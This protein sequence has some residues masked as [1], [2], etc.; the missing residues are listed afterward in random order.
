MKKWMLL[1]LILLVGKTVSANFLHDIADGNFR[2]KR[3]DIPVS[4]NDGEHFTRMTDDQTIVRISFR[5]GQV[6]DTLFSLRRVRNPI[7]SS[8][9]GYI[10]S[11]RETRILVYRNVKQ[12]YRRSYTAEYYIYDIR[13]RELD[14]LSQHVPQEAPVFSPDDRY[15]A[16]AHNN[17]LHMKKADFKSE[18]QITRDGAV[19]KISNGI[20]D[21]LYEEEFSA[22]RFFDW[23]PDSKLLAFV[24]FDESEVPTFGFQ[25][26]LNAYGNEPLLYPELVTFKYP[27]AG[28]RNPR[29]S[30]H[31]YDDFNKRTTTMQL[32]ERETDFYVP[33]IMWTRSSDQLAI[34]VMNR[35][36]NRLDMLF[37]NPRSGVSRLIQR[38]ES[39]QY[40]DYK[41][42]DF[43]YFS[44]N[45]TSFF[46]VNE[47]DGFRHIYEYRLN[48]SL[49]R[50]VTR[51]NWEVTDFY[52]VDEARNLVYFQ[53]NELSPTRRDVFVVNARGNKTRLSQVDG[54]SKA[55]FSDNFNYFVL[56]ES[57][58]TLPNRFSL[59]NHRGQTLRDL[60]S[61]THLLAQLNKE[62]AGQKE[63]F[64]FTTP[65]N[66]TLHGW[67]L[68]P[69]TFNPN[70]RHP[71]VLMQYSGPG[72]QQ[73]LEQW[74][75][76]WEYYL[77]TQ[78]YV[79]VSVDGRG[80]GGRGA[81]FRNST[82][83][84]LGVLETQD[85]VATARHF[86]TQSF[87][88]PARIGIFGWSY[89]GS[90]TLWSMSSGANI[91]KAGIAV[92]PVT[93]W[94]FYD[95][96]YT[97]RF[98]RT[99]EENMRGYE[100]TSALNQVDRLYGRLLLVHGTADDNVHF[101]NTLAYA[102]RLVEAGKQFEMQ[103]YTDKNHSITGKQTRRHLFTRFVDFF[104]RNL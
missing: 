96:A 32:N 38:Q 56:E 95:T 100:N 90:I 33:R 11:P 16:F 27:K 55:W 28:Q 54:V 7:I 60:E 72:S 99:P 41:N 43:Y 46:A 44:E 82:Y 22:V 67:I 6:V 58:P 40:I 81:A 36:Q 83:L 69:Q 87:I 79:V 78:G 39:K 9:S 50:Q 80:T 91:F 13:H 49:L 29:V 64:R 12:R 20:A 94:R 73:V 42:L 5:T 66:I 71:L 97:E 70:K 45:N 53:S 2:P 3:A 68:K 18:L 104:D 8:I 10:M 98:M 84:Q 88:D 59:R 85:Q 89:G 26:F 76:G 34:F 15:V 77:S 19:G 14:P 37:A 57:T 23:S 103:V 75:I 62:Q 102:H 65:E 93:D 52:G 63:F 1:V 30:V 48:G 101:S 74:N 4:M 61:N 86:M 25:R 47:N 21:W 24:K 51:G 92:A 17:N 35:I 31:I